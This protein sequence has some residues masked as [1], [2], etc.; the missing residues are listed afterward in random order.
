MDVWNWASHPTTMT[1]VAQR[2][3]MECSSTK[4]SGHVT[5]S[6]LDPLLF[7]QEMSVYKSSFVSTL[8]K[9]LLCVFLPSSTSDL[10]RQNASETPSSAL[11]NRHHHQTPLPFLHPLLGPQPASNPLAL[12]PPPPGHR[13]RHRRRCQ[14]AAQLSGWGVGGWLGCGKACVESLPCLWMGGCSQLGRWER[15]RP[16]WRWLPLTGRGVLGCVALQVQG[17][18]WQEV[19]YGSLEACMARPLGLMQCTYDKER[20]R[21]PQSG[22]GW[23]WW[24]FPG[25]CNCVGEDPCEIMAQGQ[26]GVL[27][28]VECAV[29]R[30][31]YFE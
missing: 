10:H 5:T 24:N 6:H 3:N 13:H 25:L 27:E 4:R 8:H 20:R 14:T 28:T 12:L 9:T 19:W 22:I 16:W 2:N 1:P 17:R 29:Q 26:T 31:T 7:T 18:G 30:V 15:R 11:L 23:C 21:G